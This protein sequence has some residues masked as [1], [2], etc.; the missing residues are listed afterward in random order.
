M[1]RVTGATMTQVSTGTASLRVTTNTGRRLSFASAHQISPC[2]GATFTKVPR[3]SSAPKTHPPTRSRCR[4]AVD[5]DTH[6]R[7]GP[8]SHRDG[9]GRQAVR[10]QAAPLPNDSRPHQP[11]RADRPLPQGHPPP[12]SPIEPYNQHN[13]LQCDSQCM[14][15]PQRT[16]DRLSLN[17]E[18][19]EIQPKPQ[20][21]RSSIFFIGVAR[22]GL[23]QR[24]PGVMPPDTVAASHSARRNTTRLSSRLAR[25]PSR[26]GTAQS[27]H[28]NITGIPPNV[29]PRKAVSR[30]QSRCLA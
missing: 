16:A 7:S 9:N 27:Q 13:E 15:V 17:E 29:M 24:R 28:R 30:H 3:Q 18:A 12:E 26:S 1:V 10:D 22:S 20:Q 2:I 19:E 14:P 5:L 11:P 4:F 25:Q 21:T 8:R 23:L 6:G